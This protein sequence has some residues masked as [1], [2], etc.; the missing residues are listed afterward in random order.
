VSSPVIRALFACLS[1]G[2]LS[3]LALASYPPLTDVN[4]WIESSGGDQR[5]VFEVFDP[6]SNSW[7]K[8]QSSWKDSVTKLV[9]ADGVVAWVSW[10]SGYGYET[11]MATYDPAQKHWETTDEKWHDTVVSLHSADGVVAWHAIRTGYGHE[12]RY[13]TYDPQKKSWRKGSKLWKDNI[14]K[15]VTADGVVAW[16]SFWSGYGW[17]AHYVVYDGA[18]QSWKHADETWFSNVQSMSIDDGTVHFTAEGDDYE[19]GYKP[20]HWYSGP[21]QPVAAFHVS[22]TEGDA[23]HFAWF[24]DMSVG[25]TSWSWLFGS[26]GSSSQ[27]STFFEFDSLAVHEITHTVYGPQGSDSAL[28]QVIVG[29]LPQLQVSPSTL[30]FSATT[31]GIPPEQQ[32]FAVQNGGTIPLEFTVS[33]SA[34]WLRISSVT[35]GPVPPDGTVAVSVEPAGLPVGTH[36]HDLVVQSPGVAGSPKLVRIVVSVDSPATLSVAPE[37]LSF[38]S[39]LGEPVPAPENV[40]IANLGSQP[41]SFTA[42]ASAPWLSVLPANGGPV[43]PSADLVVAVDPALAGPGVHAAELT[44]VAPGAL[45]SPFSVPVDLVVHTPAALVVTPSSIETAVPAGAGAL[46]ELPLVVSNAGTQP[47]S[48][49]TSVDASWLS[50][51]PGMGTALPPSVTETLSIDPTGLPPGTHVAELTVSSGP[52]PGDEILVPITIE[53]RSFWSDESS[54]SEST[55]SSVDLHLYAGFANAFRG[56]FVLGSAS[57]TEPGSLLPNGLATLPLN[58]DVFSNIVV[59][60]AN[61]PN[62]FGFHG[63][64][65]F[66]GSNKAQLNTLGPLPAGMLGAQFSFAYVLLAP[67][68]IDFAS[69]PLTFAV[70][71]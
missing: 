34:S 53:V 15:L 41:F 32:T 64:L 23:P 1:I 21:T 4:A 29:T 22:P 24:Q 18:V 5:V 56:Y 3:S 35:G 50:V 61:T 31:S 52:A 63:T 51:T 60:Y 14:T 27:R 67:P 44:L 26:E 70:E 6:E 69:N 20:S 16:F 37:V 59:N 46:V 54:L 8:S 25:A 68:A 38:S 19:R 7:K 47:L 48:Y 49:T 58:W 17:E 39:V 12:I 40:S 42:D 30:T 28:S 33:E 9:V 13:A 62:F 71:P 57:G 45:G 55:G 11:H 10:W 2:L 36:E 43:P 66:E 65:D